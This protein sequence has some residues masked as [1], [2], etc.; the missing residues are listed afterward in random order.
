MPTGAL[1][2]LA[3]FID[4]KRVLLKEAFR[5][6]GCLFSAV[7]NAT[8]SYFH[9]HAGAGSHALTGLTTIRYAGP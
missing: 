4:A 8:H 9:A 2:R 6:L 5:S 1:G 3:H 7:Q